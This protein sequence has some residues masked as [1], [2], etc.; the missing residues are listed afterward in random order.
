MLLDG[1]DG[2]VVLGSVMT[3]TSCPS[4]GPALGVIKQTFC[5]F[6]VERKKSCRESGVSEDFVKE[7]VELVVVPDV[8]DPEL[9]TELISRRRVCEDRLPA[10]R[11][12]IDVDRA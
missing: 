9:E 2:G 5:T 7:S 4:K 10:S 3:A 6:D 8:K 12:D 1:E 11:L